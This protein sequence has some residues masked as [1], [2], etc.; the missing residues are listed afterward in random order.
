MVGQGRTAADHGSVYP[1]TGTGPHYCEAYTGEDR[2]SG[3]LSPRRNGGQLPSPSHPS[4][5]DGLQRPGWH[6]VGSPPLQSPARL[7]VP[8]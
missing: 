1:M 6:T 7:A 8:S 5:Q 3:D 2:D 4:P